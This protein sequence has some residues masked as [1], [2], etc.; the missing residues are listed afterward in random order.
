MS[1]GAPA[2]QYETLLTISEVANV[3][4]VSKMTIYRLVHDGQLPSMRIGKS[5]RV[6][7]S[8]LDA[9]LGQ[10]AADVGSTDRTG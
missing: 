1:A 7:V 9:Y 5:L 3:L 2:E 10:A 6:P 4:R 8:A